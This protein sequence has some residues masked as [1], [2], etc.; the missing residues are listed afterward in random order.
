MCEVVISKGMYRTQVVSI[1]MY[2]TLSHTQTFIRVI[3]SQC[4]RKE[5]ASWKEV[6][7]LQLTVATLDYMQ[8]T[9]V[10]TFARIFI[11]IL[12]PLEKF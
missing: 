6:N 1:I 9:Q 2:A 3:I 4:I 10:Q 7:S 12:I 8:S 11:E 5:R